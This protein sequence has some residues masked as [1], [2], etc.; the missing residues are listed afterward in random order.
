MISA[1]KLIAL[2]HAH[3][4]EGTYF[5]KPHMQALGDT[6]TNYRVSRQLRTIATPAGP[7]ECYKL[8]RRE[9]VNGGRQGPAYFDVN[10]L[11]HV[12]SLERQSVINVPLVSLDTTVK[13]DE[14]AR[15]VDKMLTPGATLDAFEWREYHYLSRWLREN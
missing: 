3:H 8:E 10:T 15:L 11:Q 6:V 7:V 9:P 12:F 4:P 13:R 5:S 14:L 2:Y 1:A